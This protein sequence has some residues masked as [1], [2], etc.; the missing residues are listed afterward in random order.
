MNKSEV[1]EI[2]KRYKK[3]AAS[4]TRVTGCYVNSTKEKLV[5]F[6]QTFL[7]MEEDEQLKYMEIAKKVLSGNVDNNLLTL[8]FS[9]EEEAA[10]DSEKMLFALKDGKLKE[11]GLLDAFYDR[12]IETYS[13]SGNYLILLFHDVYDVMSKTTDNNSVDESVEVYEYVLCAICP[14]VLSKPGLGYIADENRIGSRIRDWVVGAPENGFVYPAFND[15]AADIQSLLFYTKDTTDSH[16][17]FVEKGLGCG[18]KKTITEKQ[19]MFTNAVKK[20]LGEEAD[21]VSDTLLNVQQ[22]V[23]DY[24]EENEELYV[25]EETGVILS[26][27]ELKKLLIEEAKVEERDAEAI[28][29]EYKES[30]DTEEET[31]PPADQLINEKKVK[32]SLRARE[33]EIVK[34]Y[35]VVLRVKPEKVGEI[36]TRTV[37]GKKCLC[38]PMAENEFAAVNGVNTKV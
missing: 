3:D 10:S 22:T 5:T 1:N 8:Y 35:D 19:I 30:F 18:S 11:E 15:R 4:F 16:I 6:G 17:E 20:A 37:D 12:V 28:A 24:V 33:D 36:M 32:A 29:H 9:K 31:L 27:E 13:Y 38:I 14:V 26:E 34:T 21:E 7:N 2:K 23:M 25:D